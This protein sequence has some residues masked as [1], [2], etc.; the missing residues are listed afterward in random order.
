VRSN[1]KTF[2]AWR[3]SS[4]LYARL[5]MAGKGRNIEPE[6]R[7]VYVK[8]RAVDKAGWS[9]WRTIGLTVILAAVWWFA[10]ETVRTYA[11]WGAIAL[12]LWSVVS[13]GALAGC[14]WEASRTAAD[15]MSRLNDERGEPR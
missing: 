8:M 3:D 4:E 14:F 11:G 12:V 10:D 9:M 6:A 2:D 5:L 13:V 7:L 15:V 1:T